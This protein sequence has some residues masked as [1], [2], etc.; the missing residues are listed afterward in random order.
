L[1]P[2]W[3]TRNGKRDIRWA[4]A[5]AFELLV[6]AI[7]TIPNISGR[8]LTHGDNTGVI[9]GWWR[10]RH[11]NRDV[12]HVFQ[13]INEFTHTLPFP[14]DIVT[15]YV[16]SAANPAD[17]P[18]RGIYGPTSLLLPPIQL[19]AELRDFIIDSTEPLS[20]TEIR[21]LRDGVYSIPATKV[22]NREYLRQ[23]A[24]E[25]ARANQAEEEFFIS[26]ALREK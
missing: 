9:E 3:K 24:V 13:R 10:G 15:S 19:P 22:I 25:R 17:E 4:E 12:N 20:T 7:A 21:L 18:S 2:G 1:I 11:R 5:V 6:Y 26:E 16:P 14:F 8:I 23:Q